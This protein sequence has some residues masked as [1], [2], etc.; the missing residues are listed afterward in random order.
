MKKITLLGVIVVLILSA[1]AIFL[2]NQ[3]Q[4][5]KQEITSLNKK[6]EDLEKQ[7]PEP[8]A[9]KPPEGWKEYVDK[10]YGFKI[11]YPGEFTSYNETAEVIAFKFFDKAENVQIVDFSM[12]LSSDAPVF[13]LY[14]YI[15]NNVSDVKS[16]IPE[17]IRN[18][19]KTISNADQYLSQTNINE[20]SVYKLNLPVGR[21]KYYIKKDNK[22]FVLSTD[23]LESGSHPELRSVFEQMAQ[24]FKF[25]D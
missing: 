22:V 19:A 4:N 9:E 21:I 25:I 11:W 6:I 23:Y 15:Y 16:F 24:S 3:N 20:L 8:I 14:T 2:Y 12:P 18:E 7:K 5:L 17:D 1:S 13:L 10:E